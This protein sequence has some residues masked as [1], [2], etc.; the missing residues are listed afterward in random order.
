MN[1]MKKN[2]IFLAA[3]VA[4]LLTCL[5][6]CKAK[7]PQ[8]LAS[9]AL[10]LDLSAGSEVS[11]YDTHS[12]NGDGTSCIVLSFQDDAV[13]EQIQASD[14][15]HPLPLDQTTR[16]LVYGF[17]EETGETSYQIGPYLTDNSGNPLVPEVQNGSYFLLD[18]QAEDGKAPGSDILNRGSFNFTFGLYDTDTDILYCCEL[19]T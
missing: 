7:T 18:R 3:A 13:L 2:V 19:D 17:S 4:L 1:R 10:S 12:G 9:E 5:T 8:D 6:A 11:S 15:W 16:V 14:A